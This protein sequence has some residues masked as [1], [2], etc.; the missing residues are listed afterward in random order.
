MPSIARVS[1][2]KTPTE[3]TTTPPISPTN[4]NQRAAAPIP[5]RPSPQPVHISTPPPVAPP[6]PSDFGSAPPVAPPLPFNFSS[7]VPLKQH[8]LESPKPDATS[9]TAETPK[10]QSMSSEQPHDLLKDIVAFGGGGGLK[11]G[12]S[13]SALIEEML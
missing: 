9:P 6:L 10:K 1:L 5:P 4:L 12:E 7:A 11:V 3:L 13:L 8:S 2:S